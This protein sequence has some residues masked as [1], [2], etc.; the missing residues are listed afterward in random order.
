MP[1]CCDVASHETWH[2][3]SQTRGATCPFVTANGILKLLLHLVKFG[4]IDYYINI[5]QDLPDLTSTSGRSMRGQLDEAAFREHNL[6][7][8]RIR[9]P[10]KE[11]LDCHGP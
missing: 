8:D 9:L 4:A 11:I 5:A 1:A 3:D 2:H 7:P 10:A 6:D